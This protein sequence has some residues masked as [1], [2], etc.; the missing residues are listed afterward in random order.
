MALQRQR[1]LIAWLQ[2][3][4]PKVMARI[5]E[6]STQG[7]PSHHTSEVLAQ[8]GNS[9]ACWQEGLQMGCKEEGSLLCTASQGF[10]FGTQRGIRIFY[11]HPALCRGTSPLNWHTASP[12]HKRL[13]PFPVLP[14]GKQGTKAAELK[15]KATGAAPAPC[16][17][18][19]GTAV[20]R[21]KLM[22]QLAPTLLPAGLQEKD[23]SAFGSLFFYEFAIVWGLGEKFMHG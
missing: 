5:S 23:A 10:R 20:T 17:L 16:N 7:W 12:H 13:S 11:I 8:C 9:R 6:R 15:N 3:V 4:L 21:R 14:A 19:W 18:L 1:S 2:P 22:C